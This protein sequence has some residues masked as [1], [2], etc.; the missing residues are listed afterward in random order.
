[1]TSRRLEILFATASLLL[2][3]WARQPLWVDERI[4]LMLVE[5]WSALELI[6]ILPRYQPH[7]PIYYLLVEFAGPF[8]T[9]LIGALA[10]AGTTVVSMRMAGDL[11]S[12]QHSAAVTGMFVSMSPFLVVQAGWLRMYSILT[13]LLL[14]GLMYALRDDDRASVWFLAASMVHPFG[15]FGPLWNAIDRRNARSVVVLI[16]GVV[17]LALLAAA[18][19]FLKPIPAGYR[20]GANTFTIGVGHGTVPTLNMMFITPI[21]AF[22]GAP[23]LQ[24]EAILMIAAMGLVVI[25][26]MEHDMRLWLWIWLPV[27][28]VSA[29][30]LIH[31]V[32]RVKYFGFIGPAFIVAMSDLKRPCKYWILIG[33][34]IGF[35]L[36][37]SWIG[38][39][40]GALVARRIF[41]VF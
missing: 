12:S 39:Y 41:V 21:A 36:I 24:L 25:W 9:R 29:A 20:V 34:T 35:T 33:V 13:F 32:Y 18:H 38:R 11:Y 1:M 31:P 23:H 15:L 26:S 14:T 37:I 19:V 2:V 10:M 16:I 5:R 3:L 6:T 22:I 40:E 17:P 4:T 7:Y 27:L 28:V 30:S 8:L